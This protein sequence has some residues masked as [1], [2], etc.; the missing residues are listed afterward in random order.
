MLKMA[1]GRRKV[2]LHAKQ[3][4]H[5]VENAQRSL[6]GAEEYINLYSFDYHVPE[7][8]QAQFWMCQ[9]VG[10]LALGKKQNSTHS[11]DMAVSILCQ[12]TPFLGKSP[13]VS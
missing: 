5:A 6:R 12:D 1:V 7:A 4:Q 13:E 3:Y 8:L 9:S 2:E 11:L 10:Q